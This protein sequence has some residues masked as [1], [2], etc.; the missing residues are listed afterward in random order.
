[1]KIKELVGHSVHSKYFKIG[2]TEQDLTFQAELLHRLYA[3]LFY[4]A[5]TGYCI[6]ICFRN[7]NTILLT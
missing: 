3:P 2:Y 5:K 4:T 7:M 6:L 1:M